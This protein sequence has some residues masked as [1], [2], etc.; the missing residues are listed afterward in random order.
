MFENPLSVDVSDAQE[1]LQPELTELENNAIF[2]YSFQ[3]G[4]FNGLL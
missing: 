1:N 4:S 2:A 3:P